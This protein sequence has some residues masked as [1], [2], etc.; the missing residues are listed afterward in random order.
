MR[1]RISCHWFVT[2]ALRRIEATASGEQDQKRKKEELRL[3]PRL[4]QTVKT[5][6]TVR[7]PSIVPHL[8]TILG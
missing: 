3:S 4:R 2:N 8:G 1:I 6:L 5:L 7:C